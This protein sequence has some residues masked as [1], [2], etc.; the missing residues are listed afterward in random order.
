MEQGIHHLLCRGC[1]VCWTIMKCITLAKLCHQVQDPGGPLQI[2][3]FWW[4]ES[5]NQS[6]SKSLRNLLKIQMTWLSH[7][8]LTNSKTELR[9]WTVTNLV[10]NHT[11]HQTLRIARKLCLEIRA[12]HNREQWPPS[13][14]L[15]PPWRREDNTIT[16]S[17]PAEKK[18]TES[19]S[20]MDLIVDSPFFSSPC[21]PTPTSW[22]GSS[23]C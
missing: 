23:S 19:W 13:Y 9:I 2:T 4:H 18:M 5:Q 1:G 15:Q 14:F 3:W 7:S 20:L 22:R 17:L 10:S 16:T 6:A 12:G 11:I 8:D 21:F